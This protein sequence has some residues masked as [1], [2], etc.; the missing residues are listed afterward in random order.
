MLSKAS[1]AGLLTADVLALPDILDPINVIVPT[2]EY[3]N[4]Y[5]VGGA[6]LTIDG[7][8]QGKAAWLTQPYFIRP[9]GQGPDYVGYP[10]ITRNR[11]PRRSTNPTP[12]TGKL[13]CIA[14]ATPRSICSSVR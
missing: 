8:P 3:N 7:S 14:M 2:R 9:E 13:P 5:R 12:I 11:L 1:E 10:A 4:R 6:K